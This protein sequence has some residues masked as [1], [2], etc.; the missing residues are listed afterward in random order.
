MTTRRL[1]LSGVGAAVP[2]TLKLPLRLRIPSR[3]TPIGLE[4]SFDTF[5][6]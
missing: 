4:R 3:S 2:V 5:F 6:R 1:S